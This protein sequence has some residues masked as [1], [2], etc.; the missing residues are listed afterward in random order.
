ML[1]WMISLW[2]DSPKSWDWLCHAAAQRQRSGLCDIIILSRSVVPW[3]LNKG[4]S[5]LVFPIYELKGINNMCPLFHFATS[6]ENITIWVTFRDETLAMGTS[7]YILSQ[8]LTPSNRLWRRPRG[9]ITLRR[10]Q[11]ARLT[12]D[13]FLA[14]SRKVT[15]CTS[16]RAW[17]LGRKHNISQ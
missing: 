8:P 5:S 16:F 15:G 17:V 4:N 9:S 7:C 10:T 13:I 6:L 2:E 12:E 11:K 3:L 1:Q 14:G